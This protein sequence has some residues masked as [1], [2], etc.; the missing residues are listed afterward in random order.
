M[1]RRYQIA[2]VATF[3][4]FLWLIGLQVVRPFFPAD[5]SLAGA[6]KPPPALDWD[7]TSVRTG[8]TFRAIDRWYDA[9]AGL[10]R[11]FVR[12]DNQVSFSLFDEASYHGE[13]TQVV[14]GLHDW[15]FERT[16]IRSSVEPGTQ[17]D[18]QLRAFAQTIRSVQEKLARRSVPFQLII[19]PNK[20]KVYP[21]YVPI[22]Y[23]AGRSPE[24]IQ[25][26]FERA[27]PFFHEAGVHFY[28]GPARYQEW[29]EA[30]ISD[31]FARSG[32]HWSYDSALR[33]LQEIRTEL[34]PLL[35]RSIPPLIL[36]SRRPESPS[37]TD[38]DLLDLINLLSDR[39]YEHTLP[40]PKLLPNTT[41][42][43]ASLPRV[44]WVHDSFGWTLIQLLYSAHA[45]Q[46]SESLFYFKNI[47]RIPGRIETDADISKIN[48]DTFL[49]HY[50]AVVMV[51]TEIAFE[52]QGWG[53]FHTLDRFLQ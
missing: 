15:L 40:W 4:A 27:R 22:A 6:S 13:G 3:V 19:A 25:T 51:W 9:H 8:K 37:M 41:T 47:Y 52:H 2:L 16:Y 42:P 34:N 26:N 17:T 20:A 7:P 5:G 44:L 49:G 46:P 21:E 24:R 33:V 30:G 45:M 35:R 43:D 18:S 14:S 28:D 50:D 10:R 1:H 53:F 29:K 36:A 38:R 32:T 48:W 31:L 11:T 23:L 12:L 39:P